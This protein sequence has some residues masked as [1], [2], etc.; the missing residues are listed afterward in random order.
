LRGKNNAKFLC[1][2]D[3][4]VKTNLFHFIAA[5]KVKSLISGENEKLARLQK[6]RKSGTTNLMR[7]C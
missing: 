7:E 2:T 4:F 6:I 5:I 3:V 1:L